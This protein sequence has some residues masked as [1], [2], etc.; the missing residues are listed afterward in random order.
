MFVRLPDARIQPLDVVFSQ[1]HQQPHVVLQLR[2]G[3]CTSEETKAE[4]SSGVEERKRLHVVLHLRHGHCRRNRWKQGAANET[5]GRGTR[6]RTAPLCFQTAPRC[7][8]CMLCCS[9][10]A[11][12]VSPLLLNIEMLQVGDQAGL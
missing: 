6:S 5:R 12:A 10:T 8:L 9:L 2:H 7:M 1:V 3:H 4:K 11:A